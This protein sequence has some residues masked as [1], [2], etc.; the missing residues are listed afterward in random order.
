VDYF[1][2]VSY[3]C[4]VDYIENKFLF[5]AKNEQLTLEK[6]EHEQIRHQSLPLQKYLKYILIIMV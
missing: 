6:A 1:K 4:K 5:L 3:F 2:K